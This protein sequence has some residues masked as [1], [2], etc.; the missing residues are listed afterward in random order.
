MALASSPKTAHPAPHRLDAAQIRQ[1]LVPDAP[2]FPE[3]EQARADIPRLRQ[4]PQVQAVLAATAAFLEG[5]SQIPQTGY[6]SY[7]L[8]RRTGDRR[9]FETPYFLKRAR[10]SSLALRMFLGQTDLKDIIQD[11]LISICEESNWVLPAHENLAIDLFAAET[12]FSLAE[13]LHLLGA[14]LDA[15]IHSRVRAEIER[16]VF[17]TYLQFHQ[18]LWWYDGSNN[19]NGVCNS[20]V[21]AAFLV[22]ERDPARLSQALE[23]ALRGLGIFLE[24]AFESDGSSTE[25][26]G[27]WQYGLI[28][29]A[30]L[31]EM[32]RARTGGA[33]DLLANDRMRA[34]AAYPTRLLLSGSSFAPF[35]D[36]LEETFFEP[37][38][39]S[40]LSSRTGLAGLGA[41]ARPTS[42][43]REV[44][45]SLPIL[46]R[47]IFWWDGTYSHP[48]APADTFL[49][50]SGIARLVSPTGNLV[51]I[52]KAGHNAENHNHNDVGSFVVH[53][54]PLRDGALGETFLTDPG[55]G[56]YTRQ[57]FSDQRYD[58]LFANS[59]GHSVP[60]I[61]GKLQQTGKDFAGEILRIETGP[62]QKRVEMEIAQAYPRVVTAA[63]LSARR[64][65]ALNGSVLTLTDTY[66]FNGEPLDVEEAFLTWLDVDI[67]GAVAT[68]KGQHSQIQMTI[69]TPAHANWELEYLEE[70]CRQNH[71]TTV[72]KRLHFP[73]S[74]QMSGKQT[75][76]M[77]AIVRI[78]VSETRF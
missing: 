30:A 27:Y 77:A 19:W 70:A 56:L 28:N 60:R 69:E 4:Q 55:A 16:R 1:M 35:S 24:T 57:Y 65:L 14:G 20:S 49:P 2:N 5:V 41:L 66:Q 51:T 73:L 46:L 29:Y 17:N 37:G 26:V 42:N 40:R 12:A 34:I 25:G 74:A 68:I 6:T 22:L 23:I 72:L 52:I 64:T 75:N 54:P 44:Q 78:A 11:Y 76:K 9:E 33:I 13:T 3:L 39:L 47:N 45:D 32:L 62:V 21:A 10:L 31:A 38:F 67:Q 71:K 58:N 50:G 7:R 36:G 15:E 43:S 63:L 59:Y 53:V 61:G 8:F 18:M 48:T